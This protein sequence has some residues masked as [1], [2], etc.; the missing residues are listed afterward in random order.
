MTNNTFFCQ[1]QGF[2]LLHVFF[3]YNYSVKHMNFLKG[4]PNRR[5]LPLKPPIYTTRTWKSSNTDAILMSYYISRSFVVNPCR[6]CSTLHLQRET[7]RPRRRPPSDNIKKR[8][9]LNAALVSI[10]TSRFLDL[11]EGKLWPYA[12]NHKQKSTR[13]TTLTRYN[14]HIVWFAFHCDNFPRWS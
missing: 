2:L 8:Q 4:F 13:D 12:E 14:S 3:L 11:S 6:L 7:I 1:R 9:C 10:A 5:S